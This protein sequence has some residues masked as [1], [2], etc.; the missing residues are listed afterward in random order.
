MGGTGFLTGM[1]AVAAGTYHSLAVAAVQ[2]TRAQ[3]FGD[4][5]GAA[6]CGHA[7]CL[8]A[9]PRARCYDPRLG[10]FQTKPP[11]WQPAPPSSPTLG[12]SA[13]PPRASS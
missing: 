9:Y 2:G 6:P 8:P 3:P 10:R 5:G 1:S 4:T 11:S 7:V 13:P 12:H